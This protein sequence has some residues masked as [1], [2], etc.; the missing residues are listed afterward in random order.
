MSFLDIDERLIELAGKMDLVFSPIVDVKAFPSGVDATLVEGAVANTDYADMA[1]LVR[2]NSRYVIAFG[3]CA[4]TGNVTAM[5]NPIPVESVL[6]RSYIDLADVTPQI[7]RAAPDD[8]RAAAHGAPASRDH[9]RR[10]LPAR[11][12]AVGG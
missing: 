8:C 12:S 9:R 10:C 4:V 1:R 5:R 7:P 11:L 3:D 2:R 6:S